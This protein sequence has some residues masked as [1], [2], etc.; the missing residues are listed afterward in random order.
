MLR[1]HIE[2]GVGVD[3]G[4]LA[5]HSG[6]IRDPSYLTQDGL[7]VL[8]AGRAT[9][10]TLPIFLVGTSMGGA[11]ALNVSRAAAAAG[12]PVTGVVGL[13]PMTKI[14][15]MPPSWQVGFGGWLVVINERRFSRL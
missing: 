11:I 15:A 7:A 4:A 6:L 14:K 10:P 5:A 3:G 2:G 9:H 13:A 1:A 12:A 8:S